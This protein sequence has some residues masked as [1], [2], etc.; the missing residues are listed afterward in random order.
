MSIAN[1]IKPTFRLKSFVGRNSRMTNA[2]KQ[3]YQKCCSQLLLHLEDGLVLAEDVFKRNAPCILEIGFGSGQS[4]LSLATSQ[5]DKNFIGVETHKPGIGA[6]M[7]GVQ[8]HQLQNIRVFH[9]DVVDVLNQC[10]PNKSLDGIQIFFPDPWQK[11]RHH[12]RRL[13]QLEFVQLLVEKLKQHGSL[14]LATDWE[15]YAKHMLQVLSQIKELK[16]LSSNNQFSNRSIYRP[17]ET[18]F[19]RRALREGRHI[20]ELQ[21]QKSSC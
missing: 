3:A 16:N 9:A 6:L 20:F 5:A 14:H 13:I 4:L 21:F 8:Q 19:E 2:Q 12:G 7:M 18:K 1:V 15:D 10:I 11:R 17:I